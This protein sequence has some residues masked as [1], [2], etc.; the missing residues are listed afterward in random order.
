[1]TY[2]ALPKKK[3]K[4]SMTKKYDQKACPSVS[5]TQKSMLYRDTAYLKSYKVIQFRR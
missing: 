5:M 2:Q 1:M 3:D 4:S